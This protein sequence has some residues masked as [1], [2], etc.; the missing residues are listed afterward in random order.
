MPVGVT[1]TSAVGKDQRALTCDWLIGRSGACGWAMEDGVPVIDG[2][3]PIFG[4]SG[5]PL[6][7]MRAEQLS[8]PSHVNCTLLLD[9]IECPLPI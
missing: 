4:R 1:A 3:R 8:H 7:M 2:E 5:R 9:R 6:C